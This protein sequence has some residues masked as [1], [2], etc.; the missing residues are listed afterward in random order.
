MPI[1]KKVNSNFFKEWSSE[2]A[3]VLGFFAADGCMIKNNR[4]A[5]FIEFHITDKELL[6][7]I[8]EVMGSDHKISL[9]S[10]KGNEKERHRLQIGS[11]EMY[12]DLLKLG[13]SPRKTKTVRL[14]MIPEKYFSHFVRGYFDGDGNVYTNRFWRKDRNKFA[15]ALLSGFTSGSKKILEEMHKRLKNCHVVKG[16]SLH[17]ASGAH[18][19]YFSVKDSG[20]L[21]EFMYNDDQDLFLE[22]KKIKFEKYFEYKGSKMGR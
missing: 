3:Y 7:K 20:N 17:F 12:N 22:R 9:R 18:R 5:H 11:K 10:S 8:R 1:F 19:L 2:M 14:P 16:G 15:R 21:F 6:M 13:F 4:G